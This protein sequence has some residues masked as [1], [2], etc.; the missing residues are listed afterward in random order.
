MQDVCLLLR[1]DPQLEADVNPLADTHTR[2]RSLLIRCIEMKRGESDSRA[3]LRLHECGIYAGNIR[4]K[5]S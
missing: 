2:E 5:G 3:V 1:S 4:V